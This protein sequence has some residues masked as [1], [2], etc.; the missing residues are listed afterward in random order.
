VPTTPIAPQIV[1][2]Q[3]TVN[4]PPQIAPYV[5]PQQ[6][7]EPPAHVSVITSP[8]WVSLPGPDEF[9]RYYPRPAEAQNASGAVTLMCAVSASG[10][11]RN[12]QVEKETP[13]GLGFGDAAKKL[14]A[15]FKMS[16]QTRD[17]APVDGA[18]IRIP[19]RFT[20]G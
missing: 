9:S 11:V 3:L 2:K 17:G 14:S 18:S 1:P 15:Y 13:A 8:N 16:P 6:L 5:A 19:I 12:C 4:D 7:P 20:L 10:Q